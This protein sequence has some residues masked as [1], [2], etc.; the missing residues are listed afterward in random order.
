MVKDPRSTMRSRRWILAIRYAVAILLI[1]ILLTR[2]DPSE[3]GHVLERANLPFLLGAMVVILFAPICALFR[4]Y[5]ILVALP[6][7][8]PTVRRAFMITML[9]TSLNSVLPSK[10]GDLA[11]ALYTRGSLGLSAG[12]GTVVLERMVDLFFLGCLGVVG[13]CAV[14]NAWSLWA[15]L[16]IFCGLVVI[17]VIGVRPNRW[18][19]RLP[20]RAET[21]AVQFRSVF[22][23]WRIHPRA[24]CLTLLGSLAVWLLGG[25]TVCLLI[26]G[27]APDVPFLLGLSVYP[28]AVL[29][30]MLPISISGIGVRDA[31]LIALLRP[32][33]S[34]E[35]AAVVALG[36][37]VLAYWWVAL[38]SLPFALYALHSPSTP[39][40]LVSSTTDESSS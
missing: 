15:S 22:S 34:P 28:L 35:Q 37:T 6:G 14:G 33:M 20:G 7:A 29:A 4:W 19:R 3:I 2:I 10:G 24:M 5:G 16:S 26:H 32:Y 9:A 40:T 31:A 30:G 13:Y 1:S 36:Y 38:A 27:V 17:Y 8:R 21:A 18:T 23:Q 39:E 12:M 11:K 25:T